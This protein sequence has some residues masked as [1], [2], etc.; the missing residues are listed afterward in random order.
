MLF[1]RHSI[2]DNYKDYDIS[3]FTYES[4]QFCEEIS[5]CRSIKYRLGPSRLECRT[6][7]LVPRLTDLTYFLITGSRW[8][9]PLFSV[10]TL[11]FGVGCS[12][13]T[14]LILTRPLYPEYGRMTQLWSR[15][16]T[17]H[18]PNESHRSSR[19]VSSPSSPLLFDPSSLPAFGHRTPSTF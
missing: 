9:G 6:K 7:E 19:L 15:L 2:H 10:S 12:F 17:V 5:E 4:L 1:F 16:Q 11:N 3:F 14:L 18:P 13:V 8:T